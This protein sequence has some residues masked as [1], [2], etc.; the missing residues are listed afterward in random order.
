MNEIKIDFHVPSVAGIYWNASPDFKRLPLGGLS[1]CIKA[2]NHA[3]G[4]LIEYG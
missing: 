4:I 3:P 2:D 1:R